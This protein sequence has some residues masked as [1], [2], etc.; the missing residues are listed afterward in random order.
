MKKGILLSLALLALACSPEKKAET[1]STP[2][3]SRAVSPQTVTDTNATP[4]TIAEG[5]YEYVYPYS[6]G[7]TSENHYI[8]LRKVDNLY[9]G[10]YYGTSDEFDEAREGYLPGFF[11]TPMKE[12][13]IEDDT[14][15]FMLEVPSS[16]MFTQTVDLQF[17]SFRQASESGYELWPQEMNLAP[18]RYVG[19]ISQDTLFFKGEADF[20][21]KTFVK[22]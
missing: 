10:L 4:P 19:V 7:D 14:I 12:L 6:A 16:E 8:V 9:Q 15:R 2:S 18:K 13:N 5:T 17:E 20:L 3:E 1:N 11:V 22:K 21:D